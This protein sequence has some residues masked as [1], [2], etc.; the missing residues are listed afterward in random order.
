MEREDG[1]G[2]LRCAEM[3]Y[4]MEIWRK[5]MRVGQGGT[6]WHQVRVDDGEGI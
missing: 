4:I 2:E 1:E 5:G 3:E 6:G